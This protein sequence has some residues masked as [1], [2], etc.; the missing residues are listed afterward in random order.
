[1]G[2]PMSSA[3]ASRPPSTQPSAAPISMGNVGAQAPP[4]TKR[5]ASASSQGTLTPPPTAPRAPGAPIAHIA[6]TP[7]SFGE[8]DAARA[9][10]DEL[11]N[12]A[13]RLQETAD[14][15][16]EAENAR[17]VIFQDQEL[18]RQQVFEERERQRQ[19]ELEARLEAALSR[20]PLP[21]T[22]DVPPHTLDV[23]QI[24]SRPASIH[25]V[26]DDLADKVSI[27]DSIRLASRA[28]SIHKEELLQIVS[29]E[30][31]EAAE[32]R[33]E[34]EALQKKNL[35]EL[36]ESHARLIDEKDNRIKELEEEL[37]KLRGEFEADK[38]QR[39]MQDQE[40]REQEQQNS[41][42]QYQNIHQQ[43]GEVTELVSGQRSC[44]EDI[45]RMMEEQIREK[46]DRRLQKSA[47]MVQLTDMIR[48]IQK[49]M[50]DD[51]QKRDAEHIEVQTKWRDECQRHHEET[52]E[53]VKATS[54]LQVPFNVQ[55]YLDEFSRALASEVRLLLGEVGRIREERRALQHE[56]SDL[57][58]LRAK[59]SPG[60]QYEPDWKPPAGA[61]GPPPPPPA[62]EMP[63]P[64]PT[65]MPQV[66]PGWRPI[67]P[68]KAK[69]KK[70]QPAPQPAASTS[71]P[72]AQHYPYP[73]PGAMDPE[74]RSQVRSFNQWIRKSSFFVQV[75][76]DPHLCFFLVLADPSNQV[77]PPPQPPTT[78]LAQE[79]PHPRGPFGTPS[80]SDDGHGMYAH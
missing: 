38:Q 73:R 19:A 21:S 45:R 74:L 46:E 58:A 12:T 79:R 43:L 48:T 29:D 69:K 10:L 1:M 53:A 28:A 68:K 67:Y 64:P 72:Q 42:E 63:P 16:A 4:A 36:K 70:T 18:K 34:S 35:D 22:L 54:N 25:S 76:L 47:D 52:I 26:G 71:F 44:C 11:S 9:Q 8:A 2:T 60:G 50:D 27:A 15:V 55:G 78:M 56:I 6:P 33:R 17:E 49:E 62:D 65:E 59:Y 14:A 32:A 80:I 30:R 61:T 3:G 75:F 40:A 77:T 31:E 41:M 51:R 23:P 57:L 20:L 13:H 37:A 66:R 39:S 7:F 24:E 5:Q